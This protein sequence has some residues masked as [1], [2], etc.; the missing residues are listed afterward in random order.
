[1]KETSHQEYALPVLLLPFDMKEQ[2]NDVEMQWEI[3]IGLLEIELMRGLE[4]GMYS[5]NIRTGNH[6]IEINSKRI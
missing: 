2:G 1:M 6:S 5:C 4:T 3:I